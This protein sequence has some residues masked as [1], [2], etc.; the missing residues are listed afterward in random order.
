MRM[1][2]QVR[3]RIDSD[4]EGARWAARSGDVAAA[5]VLLEDAHVLSQ[6]WAVPHVRTHAAMLALA[7]RTRAGRETVGQ[8]ARLVLAGPGSASG[9]Y[10]VGNTGRSSVSMFAPMPVPDGVAELLEMS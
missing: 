8:I 6:G 1:S 2:T 7:V 9:R 10:P 5:W 4:M 3:D